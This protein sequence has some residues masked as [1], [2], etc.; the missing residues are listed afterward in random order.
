M[1]PSL[2]ELAQRLKR[3]C[4]GWLGAGE[5]GSIDVQEGGE[6]DSD[7]PTSSLHCAEQVTQLV[8]KE[9]QPIKFLPSKGLNH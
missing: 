2:V 3:L 9:V 6:W 8:F 5:A 1:I 4:E 7:D